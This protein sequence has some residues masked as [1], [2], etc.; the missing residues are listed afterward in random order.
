MTA[1]N[2]ALVLGGKTGLVG[3]A[4]M[5]ELRDAG[6]EAHA[7]SR[8]ELDFRD[9]KAADKLEALIDHL[10]PSCIFNGVAYTNVDG[11]E[12]DPEGATLLNRTLPSML[13]RLTKT[14]PSW[15]V[16]FSTDFVFNGKQRTPY[17]TEDAPDPLSVYG[18][19]KLAGEEAI[20]AMDLRE[21]LIIRTAWVFGPGRRN[22]VSA[23]LDR[24]RARQ[25]LRVVHDQVGSPT[26]SV[27]L[28][29]YALKLFN[30]GASGLYHVANSGQ[31]NRCELADEAVD[32]A[33]FECTVN[34]VS[35]SEFPQKAERPAWSVLDCTRFTQITGVAP[36]PWPQALRDYVYQEY[37]PE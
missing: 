28:A 19:T 6:W 9:V 25:E 26:Y 8:D 1:N 22:F 36:R 13:A 23:I 10:E 35:S 37:P 3:Q 34:P 16:H 11:A 24:C 20:L 17:S 14:R 21:Y 15:L 32:I 4:L 30:C 7:L 33:Q 18:K 31:C 27:D 29:D 5:R 2:K 12:D